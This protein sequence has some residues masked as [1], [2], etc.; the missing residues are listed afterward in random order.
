MQKTGIS[1]FGYHRTAVE[2][3]GYLRSRDYRITIIDDDEDNLARARYAGFETARLDYRDD[4]ELKKL[5]LG[6]DTELVFSLFPDDAENVFLVISV[7]ALAPNV[8]IFTIAHGEQ[9][10]PKLI[11]A[12][13]NKVVETHEIA[14]H[15]VTDI[16]ERPVI[17]EILD[18]TLFGQADLSMAEVPVTA[19]SALCGIMVKDIQLGSD[20]NLV[21]VGIVDREMNEYFIYSTEAM[22]R[23]L[24]E[25]DVLVIIGT[26]DEIARARQDLCDT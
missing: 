4:A 25:G 2:V 12:G 24:E 14:G 1:I 8:R 10:I 23:Y 7:R 16:L 9:A 17:T 21:L 19:G 18:K 3:A 5:G 20:Y 6:R 22:Q 13:A 15:R 26:D 11:A